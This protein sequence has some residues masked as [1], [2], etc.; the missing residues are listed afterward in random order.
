[1]DRSRES[2][3]QIAKPTM[4]QPEPFGDGSASVT[5]RES[6]FGNQTVGA[7]QA[8]RTN[9]RSVL[10]EASPKDRSPRKVS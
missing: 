8:A 4:E 10:P 2:Q 3:G 7:D 6:H 1:M 5:T 9:G